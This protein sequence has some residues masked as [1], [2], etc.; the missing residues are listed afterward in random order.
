MTEAAKQQ[1]RARLEELR[2]IR[3]ELARSGY[4]ADAT[5]DGNALAETW[6]GG[7]QEPAAGAKAPAQTERRERLEFGRGSGAAAAASGTARG[8]QGQLADRPLLRMLLDERRREAG[9]PGSGPAGRA[10]RQ[11]GDV[12]NDPQ[13][14]RLRFWLERIERRDSD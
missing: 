4:R 11:Q 7:V 12:V 6:L 9:E 5:E 8:G 2:R 3:E 14:R 13:R 1:R 10:R